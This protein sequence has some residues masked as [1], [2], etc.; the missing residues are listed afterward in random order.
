MLTIVFDN[1]P[2]QNKNNTVLRLV[3]YLVEMGIFPDV[4]IVFLVVGHTKN[5][6]DRLFNIMKTKYRVSNAFTMDQLC[7]L[8]QH[9]QIVPIQVQEG[10]IKDYDSFLGDYYRRYPKIEEFHIFKCKSD[11]IGER[12]SEN[13]IIA[14]DVPGAKQIRFNC[15]KQGFK[16]RSSFP[17]GKKGLLS[18]IRARKDLISNDTINIIP[19]PGINPYK[20]VELYNKYRDLLDEASKDITCPKPSP[21]V[22]N[23]VKAEKDSNKKRKIE[24]KQ[25]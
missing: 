7:A 24:K 4:E 5:N 2:G 22:F 11:D 20:Q 19:R 1:C 6:A 8:I 18:A 21:D 25:I 17:A 14:S 16:G 3:P 13:T 9:R 12:S 23:A 15:F 10:D